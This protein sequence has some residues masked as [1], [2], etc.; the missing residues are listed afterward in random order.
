MPPP[1][2][3][4][5]WRPTPD[6]LM[7][8]KELYS[9]GINTPNASQIQQITS[10]LSLYGKI[11]CKNVFYWFQNHKAREKQKLRKRLILGKL[12]QDDQQPRIMGQNFN[13]NGVVYFP[14]PQYKCGFLQLYYSIDF[15]S[16][17]RAVEN[18]R[19]KAMDDERMR[20]MYDKGVDIDGCM[21]T[22]RSARCATRPLET[23]QLFP[24]TSATITTL[25][26]E[27][28]A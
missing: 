23:L 9:E 20:R 8:L 21:T 19:P 25:K 24:T 14:E 1:S 17:G 18:G 26:D 3:S 15:P 7:I 13:H 6:Q 11:E 22:P 12:Q 16:Q 28:T 4:T 5:R 2:A 27:S 10:H